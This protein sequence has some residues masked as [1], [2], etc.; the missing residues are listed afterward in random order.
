MNKS[1][2]VVLLFFLPFLS[3]SQNKGTS[4]SYSLNID[5]PDSYSLNIDVPDKKVY[6]GHLK[7]GGTNDYGQNI[8]VNN[9]Y[10]SLNG[11]PIIPITGEFH[12]SRYPEAYWDEAIKKMKA[13]GVNMMATYVFWIMHEEIEGEFVWDG[14]RNVRKFV[15][16]C[17][18]NDLPVIIRIG[19]FGHGEIRNGALPDWLLAKPLSI[20]S[21]D[22]QYLFYVERLYN[23]I[24]NQLNG[25]FF[26]NGGPIIATQI[27]NEYQ[28]SAAPWGLTYPGQPLDFTSSER[29]RALTQEGVGISLEK[30]PYAELGNEHMKVLKSLVNKA[31]I[32]TP[33]Y[34]AT[35]WGNGA[36][37]PNESLPVTAAYAYPTWT[38]KRD[39]SPFYLYKDMHKDPDY[40]PVRY[41]PEDYPAFAA[42]L[43]GGIMST[44]TRRPVV[45]AKSI[46][47]L[48]NRCLGSGAN[49]IGYYMYHGG[50]TP[51]GENNFFNDEAYGYPK[52]SY[53]FQAPIG[54]F[55]QTNESFH[56]LKLLHEFV[57]TF[58]DL[59]APMQTV[60]PENNAEIKAK[61]I[62]MLRYAVR[63]KDNS[64]FLF[65]NNFQDDTLMTKKENI[66]IE[67]NTSKKSIS[68]P[69]GKGFSIESDENA[70]FPF[71]FNMNGFSLNYATAQLFTT[72]VH[73][74]ISY[75]IFFMPEGVE[76]EFSFE[77]SNNLIIKNK[78]SAK[79]I[80]NKSRWLVNGLG[81]DSFE[82]VLKNK[83]NGSSTKVLVLS[84]EFAL[85]SWSTKIDDKK[86]IMFSNVNVLQEESGFRL[87]SKGERKFSLSVYPKINKLATI[88]KGMIKG[89]SKH[90][91]FSH[92]EVELPEVK[93]Q[94]TSKKVSEKRL[95]VDF[96]GGIPEGLSNVYLKMDY[97]GDTV[98]G[99]LN[100]E[101]VAVSLRPSTPP[102]W[103]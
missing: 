69:K 42:E 97:I 103:F 39:I 31:G 70:I 28:A 80:K 29:D 40:G 54:E 100:N 86:Y 66:K 32:T 9:Y 34:T 44:Y 21:N 58:G 33:L 50:S 17:A 73:G 11:K 75:Y 35:G 7:L 51:R 22:S 92:F 67:L 53:D 57:N 95:V 61:N 12:F 45:P 52:I 36:I 47:A 74:D 4:N 27:E 25:L 96:K 37:I 3:I 13:G 20:R 15:E 43:G 23:E 62:N 24:G 89:V 18:K 87:L 79:I 16:L 60:L 10:M 84:K 1:I 55:G 30:N 78:K 93:L 65:V 6:S 88:D 38:R 48:I 63:H 94:F 64:G 76:P 2:K 72:F 102:P 49:G 99:F 41:V 56:R 82:F 83:N 98:M 46:D 5:V 71:N 101:L 81:S 85:K 19:P 68:I 26:E 8:E 14:N 90:A 91:I 59:L 77:N